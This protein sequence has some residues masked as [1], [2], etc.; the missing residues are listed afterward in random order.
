[1]HRTRRRYLPPEER[2]SGYPRH[3]I[4]R[5]R[6]RW[7]RAYDGGTV[8]EAVN[9][10]YHGAL[11]E[12]RR[13][14]RRRSSRSRSAIDVLRKN[15]VRNGLIGLAVA[16]TAAPIAINQYQNALRN[17]PAHEQSMAEAAQGTAPATDASI[18]QAWNG[19]KTQAENAASKRDSVIQKKVDEYAK[20]GLSRALAEDIYDNAV[21]A[22][23]DPD[24]AFGLVRTESS[25][26]NSATSN[27]GAIG[28][29]QLMP[30]TSRWLE[31]GTTRGDLRDPGTNL[32]I[33][34][35]YLHQLIN[36]YDGNTRLALLAYNRGPGTVDRVLS[37]GGNP[38]NGYADMVLGG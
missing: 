31:P 27:V 22:H 8:A 13:T 3:P 2:R 33:G 6:R 29:T 15:P 36:R 24:V 35:H 14:E 21:A 18:S 16:G 28:L 25:F 37:R 30:A 1:M 23:V 32:R 20:Y 12:D 26:K 4:G 10:R 17:D 7:P 11:D 5:A 19:M 38:D 9:R 34:F